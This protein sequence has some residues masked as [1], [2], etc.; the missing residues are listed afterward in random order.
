M[1]RWVPFVLEALQVVPQVIAGACRQCPAILVVCKNLT[2]VHLRVYYC[3]V[4]PIALT[5][6]LFM[7]G[8][9][10][11]VEEALK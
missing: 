8:W 3:Y 1:A 2:L 5:H 11:M 7:A 6:L 10:P 9:V 4:M